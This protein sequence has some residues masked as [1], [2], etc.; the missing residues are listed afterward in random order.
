M[1]AD[2]PWRERFLRDDERFDATAWRDRAT[3]GAQSERLATFVAPVAEGW[4][5]VVDV[6]LDGPAMS[7]VGGMWVYP[8]YRR[9]GIGRALLNAALGWSRGNQAREVSLVVVASNTPAIT[10]YASA[11]F[12]ADGAPFEATHAE[13]L[14]QRMTTTLF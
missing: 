13:V 7:E 11:G 1:L 3:A 8:A 12:Q 2:E 10:L 6:A 9:V 5:G 14:L 4:A